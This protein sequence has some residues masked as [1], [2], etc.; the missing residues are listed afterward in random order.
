MGLYI[1]RVKLDH[2]PV[3][4]EGTVDLLPLCQPQRKK[5]VRLRIACIQKQ[6]RVKLGAS[7]GS[8]TGL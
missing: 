8:C 4:D 7:R 5:L 6:C 1:P 2:L 3:D